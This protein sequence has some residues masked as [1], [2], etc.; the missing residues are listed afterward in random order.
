MNTE[1]ETPQATAGAKMLY[2]IK[3]KADTTREELVVHWFANHM[4]LTIKSMEHQASK[5]KLHARSYIVTLFDPKK[6]DDYP[7]DGVAQMRWNIPLPM[8]DEP[9]GTKPT[10]SFQQKVEPYVPWATTEYII[11]EGAGHVKAEPLML[12]NPFPCTRSGFYKVNFLVAAK[13]D[14]DFDKFFDYWLNVHVPNIKS[15]MLHVGGFR[16]VVMHSLNPQTEPYAGM[17]ELYFTD[18][19]AW[20]DFGKAFTPDGMDQWVDNKETL[21]IGANTEMIGIPD[22]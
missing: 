8:P 19:N 13:E 1:I 5:G 16:Y 11:M 7:W 4:P 20:H 9:Y 14:T 17:A 10:D 6:G 15:A 18:I 21:I 12:N 3:R 2:L 22:V